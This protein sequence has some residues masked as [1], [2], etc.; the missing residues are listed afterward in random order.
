[1]KKQN[2]QIRS[3]RRPAYT[4]R[5]FTLVELIVVITI[6]A[7]LGTI[8]FISLQWYSSQARDSKRLSDIQNIKKSLEL[9]SLNTWKYPE[10]DSLVTISYGDQDLRYQWTVWEQVAVNLSRNLNEKPTDPLTENEYTY[11]RTY[12][13]NEYELLSIYE[14]D[15]MSFNSLMPFVALA[16]K[17]YNSNLLNQTNASNSNY[18]KING[19]YNGVYVK[20]GT[21][22]IPTPS[23]INALNTDLDLE[24]QTDWLLSQIITWWNNNIANAW[25]E[26]I[27]W[28][29]TWMSVKIFSWT[30]DTDLGEDDN[31][32]KALLAQA[33]IDAYSWTTLANVWV[34]KTIV[35]T[36]SEDLVS[37]VDTFVLNKDNFTNTT[38]SNDWW[39]T[40]SVLITQTE[41]EDEAWWL[42]VDSSNDV[43]IGA[44]QWDWFCIS[45][46][47]WDFWDITWNGI[48]W[49]GWWN[50]ND[51]NYNWWDANN[52]DDYNYATY[53]LW[54][55]YPQYWQTRTLDTLNWYT[56]S[57]LNSWSSDVDW[58]YWDTII[59]R[60]KWLQTNKSNLTALQSID[61]INWATPPNGHPIPA[62]YIADCIDWVKDLWGNMEYKHQPNEWLN[63]T[64][65]YNQYKTEVT[66]LNTDTAY[67]S[68]TTYQN[69]QKYLTAWTQK[70][71]SHL[72]SAFSYITSWKASAND[73]DWDFLTWNDRW[74]Y[75]VACE[76]WLFWAV[77]WNW[78]NQY[79]STAVWS[80]DTDNERIWTSA[81]G[82]PTGTRWGRTARVVGSTGCGDQGYTSTGYRYGILSARFVVRP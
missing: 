78:S 28:W 43:Y 50:Q 21:Y 7:I 56:C 82:T 71:G 44:S 3:V 72:P 9:F 32:K 49:N 46:R 42:W 74:E 33:L 51:W 54:N 37:L 81:I 66:T 69:R 61:W 4:T 34:Y 39:T 63:E 26:A 57:A 67:L 41:C 70:S 1:M 75:Q 68:D 12:A 8:A 65:T 80:D 45:P 79:T 11:S 17:G 29:L 19:N 27:T 18:P 38:S 30:L 58:T 52:V 35:E 15:L 6:L 16:K 22:Y 5:A 53:N 2:K 25:F 59:W 31:G 23:I 13:W 76:A 60:M 64:I 73:D 40:S 10:P 47:I 20:A 48:S 36:A 77:T 62:L 24:T 14:S 55:P